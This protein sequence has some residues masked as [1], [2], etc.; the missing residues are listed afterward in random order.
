MRTKDLYK[1]RTPKLKVITKNKIK[2]IIIIIPGCKII[3]FLSNSD[4]INE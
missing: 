3:Y 2:I 1:D 4:T